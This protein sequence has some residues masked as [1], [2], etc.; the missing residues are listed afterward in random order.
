MP[1][2]MQTASRAAT[3]LTAAPTPF[4]AS[5]P[6]MAS[7][8]VHGGLVATLG[9]VMAL[10]AP[11]LP[12]LLPGLGFNADQAAHIVAAIGAVATVYGGVMA[13]IGRFRATTTLT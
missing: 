5:K 12:T 7:Q 6:I 8:T 3:A 1:T 9:G 13:I 10:V 4:V 11:M 2:A